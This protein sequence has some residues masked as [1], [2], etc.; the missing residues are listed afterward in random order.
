[1]S[2]AKRVI[3]QNLITD[4]KSLMKIENNKGPSTEP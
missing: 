1:M 3:L 4:G 2:S